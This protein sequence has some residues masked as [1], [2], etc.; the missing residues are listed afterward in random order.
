[1][2]VLGKHYYQCKHCNFLL[3]QKNFNLTEH[4]CFADIDFAKEDIYVDDAN[5]IFIASVESN[6]EDGTTKKTSVKHKNKEDKL[7]G[8]YDEILI[9][10]LRTR[11]CLW[12][13]R[14]P[15][16]ERSPLSVKEAWLEISKELEDKFDVN[17]IKKRWRNLRDCYMKARKKVTA[18]K[19][20][21]SAASTSDK[22]KDA[23]FRFFDQMQFLNDSIIS[24]PSVSNV[25]K[26]PELVNDALDTDDY[27]NTMQEHDDTMQEHDENS[28]AD[29]QMIE[30]NNTN[31]STFGV[32][33]SVSRTSSISL[34]H[35]KR[36]RTQSGDPEFK[37][38]LMKIFSQTTPADCI[39]GFL[40]Q[41][42]DILR[43]LPYKDSRL[44][45]MKI[46]NN[47]LE[48]EEKAGLLND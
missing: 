48:A 32:G 6:K 38:D 9:E 21:G 30:E 2:S 41:L 27:S 39:E 42:G 1:M 29:S 16:E 46:M 45:Q 7:W 28:I 15:V 23:G 5:V 14:I 37:K 22:K 20:S 3:P 34:H 18:Y 17:S 8:L 4:S 47:A 11:P 31:D 35:E 40:I 36:R 10:G 12:N 13:H 43:R 26:E 25:S 33:K 19:P 24:R 44:L